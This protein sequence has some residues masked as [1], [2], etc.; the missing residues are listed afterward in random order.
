[1]TNYVANQ[2]ATLHT[3]L[4][5]A[6]WTHASPG[7]WCLNDWTLR[8]QYVWGEATLSLSHRESP[9]WTMR[10]ARRYYRGAQPVEWAKTRADKVLRKIFE[11]GL[12]NQTEPE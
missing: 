5:G 12:D 9:A 10:E 6:G 3:A 7:V 4:E 2:L 1:M 11:Q 8:T